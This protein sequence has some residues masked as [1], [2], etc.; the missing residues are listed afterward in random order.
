MADPLLHLAKLQQTGQ[1]QWIGAID[2]LLRGFE[3]TVASKSSVTATEI[4]A[5][6]CSSLNLQYFLGLLTIN[7]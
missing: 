3:L 6:R 7:L 2:G 1:R 5:I 4:D